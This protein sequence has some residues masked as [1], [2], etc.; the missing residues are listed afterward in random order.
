MRVVYDA[1]PYASDRRPRLPPFTGKGETVVVIGL[2]P[3]GDGAGLRGPAASSGG[4]D[5]GGYELRL[6]DE[7]VARDREVRA[8]E[9]AHLAALGGAAASGILYDTA[10]GPGGESVAVGGRI[11]VDLAEVPGDPQATLR[12]ARSVIAAAFAPGDPSAAD[13][14]TAARAYDLQRQARRDLA[15]EDG[16]HE[17]LSSFYA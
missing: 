2:R 13:L 14:R 8:H 16:S 11:A 9:R 6:S 7:A 10:A 5:G 3:A 4:A 12:K 17:Y 1:D 15:A